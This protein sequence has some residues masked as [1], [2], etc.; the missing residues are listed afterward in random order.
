MFSCKTLLKHKEE[1]MKKLLAAL[2]LAGLASTSFAQTSAW[3]DLQNQTADGSPDQ[4]QVQVGV[5]RAITKLLSI[6]GSVS[7][8]Q[9]D[10]STTAS[11]SFKTG[12]RA[13]AGLT[14]QAPI[15]GPVDGYARLG[16]GEK[17]PNG[18][19]HFTYHSEEIGVVYHAP[20]NLHAKVGYRYRTAFQDGKGDTSNTTRLALTY[21]INKTNSI[22]LRR[23]I[24]R[25]DSA[26]GGDA[27]QTALQY[28]VKF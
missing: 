22:V 20:Y 2:A 3:V 25:A 24:L 12:G 11:K 19:E 18:T 27:T 14:A 4:S 10:Y 7:L 16:V 28:V 6:D 1:N 21:D 15:F 17:A 9:N 5:K 26:N 23:D 8:A 13:E